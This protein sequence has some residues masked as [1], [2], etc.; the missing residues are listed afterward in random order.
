MLI[1]LNNP[2]KTII[3]LDNVVTIKIDSKGQMGLKYVLI[4]NM[5]FTEPFN[6]LEEIEQRIEGLMQLNSALDLESY[7]EALKTAKEIQGGKG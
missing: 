2:E 6:S 7:N 4:G 1:R 5:I 3:N